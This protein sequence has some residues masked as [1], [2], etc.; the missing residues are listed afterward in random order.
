M[1][2]SGLVSVDTGLS[3]DFF[4]QQKLKCI[5]EYTFKDH[6]A[7]MHSSLKAAGGFLSTTKDVIGLCCKGVNLWHSDLTVT[8]QAELF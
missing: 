8:T 7:T 4:F 1:P 3:D 2:L 5:T 6:P